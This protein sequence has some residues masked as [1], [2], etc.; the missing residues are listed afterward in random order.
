[1]RLKTSK[2]TSKAATQKNSPQAPNRSA[3]RLVRA[4]AQR[5]LESLLQAALTVFEESGTDA[6][7]R[8]IAERAGVGVGTLYRHFPERSE[9]IKAVVRQEVDARAEAASVITS[10]NEPVRPSRRGCSAWSISSRPSVDWQPALHSGNPTYHSLPNYFL[11][12][13]TPLMRGTSPNKCCGRPVV[14][15]ARRNRISWCRAEGQ[16]PPPASQR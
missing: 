3:N 7:V 2:K 16:V 11:A 5:N 13:L 4:D 8:T 14:E 6:P 12:H 10:E 15:S 1:M 9:F